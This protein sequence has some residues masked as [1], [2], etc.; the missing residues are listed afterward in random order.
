[1][2]TARPAAPEA[3]RYP[4]GGAVYLVPGGS[5]GGDLGL[6]HVLL[7]P[8]AGWFL[9][10]VIDGGPDVDGDGI[11]D[12]VATAVGYEG[13]AG[14]A[15]LVSGARFAASPSLT[16]PEAAFGVVAGDNVGDYAGTGA[17]F[18]GDVMGDGAEYLAV[19]AFYADPGGLADAGLVAVFDA[20]SVAQSSMADADIVVAGPYQY[21]SIGN[22]VA[23]AGDIDGDGVDDY[24]VAVSEGDI[25]YVLPGGVASPS[26]QVD[27][28]FR[29]TG[30]GAGETGTVRMLGDVDGDGARDLA[31][32]VLDAEIRVFTTLAGDPVRSVAEQSATILPGEGALTYDVLD[33]GDI[34]DD[35]RS[36]TFVPLQWF[37]VLES[38]FAAIVFGE[39]LG[40]RATVDPADATLSAVST[41]TQSRFGYRVALSPDVDGDGGEDVI[42]GGYS[43]TEGGSDAGAVLTIPVPR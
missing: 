36:D 34:D 15:F 29:L 30:T 14:A 32:I 2:R 38:S 24:L 27:A 5:P 17:A 1:M 42:I 35:G 12:L 7:P 13:Q 28:I 21:G 25:A 39:D 37:P 8:E 16:L 20:R 18:L 10:Q 41:R 22:L 11:P 31:C 33:L 19:S 9:P 43:D 3:S 6:A 4:Y 23:A 26:A 40:F